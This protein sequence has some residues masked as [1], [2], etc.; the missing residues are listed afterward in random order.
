MDKPRANYQKKLKLEHKRAGSWRLLANEEPYVSANINFATLCRYGNGANV[1]NRE[2]QYALG[3]KKRDTRRRATLNMS[4]PASAARTLARWPDDVVREVIRL[5]RLII[6][7][8][9]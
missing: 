3:I 6:I 5:Y 9:E 1:V 2:H 7:G 4:D 8:M